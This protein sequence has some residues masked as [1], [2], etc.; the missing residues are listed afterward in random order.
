MNLDIVKIKTLRHGLK[1]LKSFLR[2]NL[3]TAYIVVP[4]KFSLFIERFV[5]ESLNISSS[6]DIQVV[7]MNRFCKTLLSDLNVDYNSISRIG[8]TILTMEAIQNSDLKYLKTNPNFNYA[9]EI[10]NT[11]SQI[12]S[13][14]I[15]DK[16]LTV[17][18]SEKFKQKISDLK[19]IYSQYETLKAS[20]I[21]SSDLITLSVMNL[22]K[23][24]LH[25]TNFYFF[26]FDDYT[27]LSL[28]F[29]TSIIKNAKNVV[30]FVYSNVKG[31]NAGIYPTETI[32]KL[33]EFCISSNIP[34]N[35]Y[36][37]NYEDDELHMFLADNLFSIKNNSFNLK[38]ECVKI[39]NAEDVRA[40]LEF[41]AR[42]IRRKILDGKKYGEFVVAINDVNE[43]DLKEIFS[44][45]EINYYLDKSVL[46]QDVGL[47]KFVLSYL[48]MQKSNFNYIDVINF[49]SFD[50][51]DG[52]IEEK[53]KFIQTVR[54]L[55]F[56][57][58]VKKEYFNSPFSE[59]ILKLQQIK[60]KK[61]STIS[62]V[63]E[64]IGSLFKELNIEEKISKNSQK[65]TDFRLKKANIQSTS[66]ILQI[67]NE[68]LKFKPN[69]N[70]SETISILSASASIVE[71]QP[72]PLTLDAVKVINAEQVCEM[73]KNL[74]IVGV[75]KAN[76]PAILQDSGVIL[77]DEINKINVYCKLG[78]TVRHINRLN[79][80]RLFNNISTFDESLVVTM[81][82]NSDSEKSILVN[83][84]Q[85]KLKYKDSSLKIHKD[86]NIDDINEILSKT[87]LVEYSIKFDESCDE[88]SKLT[89]NINNLNT[90][91][92]KT[93]DVINFV[94]AS[95]LESYFNCPRK[96]FYSRLLRLKEKEEYEIESK[97][98]GTFLHKIACDYYAFGKKENLDIDEFVIKECNK[99]IS[100]NDKLKNQKDTSI[101]ILLV[102]EAKRFVKQL[103]YME[104]YT[105]FK[106]VSA[107]FAIGTNDKNKAMKI[108]G[109]EFVGSVDR[110]DICKDNNGGNVS[111]RIVDYKTGNV[112]TSY[113]EIY[114]GE[115][116][117]LMLYSYAV[118]KM[119]KGKSVGC[120]YMP[121]R[122]EFYQD[123]SP[124]RLCGYFI[125]EENVLLNLDTRLNPKSYT[126][127]DIVKLS[128]NTTELKASTKSNLPLSLKQ[129]SRLKDYSYLIS[130]NAVREIFAGNIKP[131]PVDGVCKYCP[132]L[133]ICRANSFKIESRKLDSISRKELFNE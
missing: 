65:L 106:T 119:G 101:L 7:T 127:S 12:K 125:N 121:V 45:Y 80:F 122:N 49:A 62:D 57:G 54:K 2:R 92:V 74:Y 111:F 89:K 42:D 46:L 102:E 16:E 76:S 110:L 129:Y 78:P 13:S 48:N 52:T 11:I 41:V 39:V 64:A 18:E 4:D 59:T 82:V 35:E 93:I 26:G 68:I 97:E 5:F 17:G 15:S 10:F 124:Y 60:L 63:I 73:S 112:D 34:F 133:E 22:D 53:Q 28:L 66:Q 3:G 31:N 108:S 83:D 24:D 29:L 38:N 104:K 70:L 43:F 94:S 95:F 114:Y 72:L 87:D 116:L 115:K 36:D 55:R 40:E 81:S 51:V 88:I 107:E 105:N 8:S 44:K 1:A 90:E 9:S 21:D 98:I 118:E 61:T 132:Y 19:Q 109:K 120:F 47:F 103:A 50:F 75:S 32:A 85:N 27:R 79:K 58:E 30:D 20:Y 14:N 117:Q 130:E 6:F 91:S 123:Q 100:Q 77:D 131:S 33:K 71:I 84:L 69:A 99:Y 37:S 113:K 25:N 126:E 128:I 56:C 23:I 86:K 67:F 96:F